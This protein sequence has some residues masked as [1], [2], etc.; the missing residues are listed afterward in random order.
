MVNSVFILEGDS[1][2][3]IPE[4]LIRLVRLLLLPQ[5]EWEKVRDKGK[6]PKPKIDTEI[7]DIAINVL[8]RRLAQYPTTI[9][10]SQ[11]SV[12]LVLRF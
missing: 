4:T 12:R 7:L 5:H 1:A 6:P 3:P 11:H 10:V 9:P 8:V 2:L